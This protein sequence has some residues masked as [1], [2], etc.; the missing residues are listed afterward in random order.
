MLGFGF[1][2]ALSEHYF[3]LTLPRSKAE[4][5]DVTLSEHFEWFEPTEEV[6]IPVPLN[7]TNAHLRVLLRRGVWNLIAEDVKAEF[8][9]RLRIYGHK[10]AK[11]PQ[12]G[13]IPIDRTLGK[14]L[15]VL[16]WAVEEC[17][18]ALIPVAIR[19]WLGLVPEERWWLYTMTNA[20]TG[21]ALTGRGK[22]WRKAL[23]YAL[24]ENPVSEGLIQRRL[25]EFEL[26]PSAKKS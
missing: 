14:E 18:P 20:A 5:A 23:R 2:P 24:T 9:R 19:N 13:Q 11:W 12:E 15:C 22:G 17:D 10:T 4:S 1:Q 8:N 6:P 3:L 26:T 25:A 7:A 21:H 16:A